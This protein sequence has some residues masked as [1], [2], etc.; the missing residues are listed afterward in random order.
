LEDVFACSICRDLYQADKNSSKIPKTLP[1]QHTYCL[2][3]VQKWL[4]IAT[5]D[6]K[7]FDCPHCKQKVDTSVKNA[8]DLPTSRLIMNLIDR[9]LTNFHAV[10]NCP[11]CKQTKV[12]EVCFECSEPLCSECI[13]TDFVEWKKTTDDKLDDAK[14]VLSACLNNMSGFSALCRFASTS[15]THISLTFRSF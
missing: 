15:N 2:E 14:N 13:K 7:P 5:A 1:C 6:R 3:C 10:A 11:K 4:A 8:N 9:G 12:L